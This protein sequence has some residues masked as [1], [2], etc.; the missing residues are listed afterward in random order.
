LTARALPL[1]LLVMILATAPSTAQQLTPA[2]SVDTA[3]GYRASLRLDGLFADKELQQVLE[4]GLPMRVR[5]RIE[6]WRDRM[7]DA[8]KG[9]EIW[10]ALLTYNPL[11]KTY[12]LRT[13]GSP[14]IDHHLSSFQNARGALEARRTFSL[15]PSEP[16]RY[17]FTANIEIETLSLSDLEELERWL[18]GELRPAVSG[19]RSV[20]SAIGEGA[21]RMLVR[22]LSLPTRTLDLKTPRFRVTSSR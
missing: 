12:R 17:Y 3:G 8:S 13:H 22:I 19:D 7:I 10:N 1:F 14:S 4:S 21:K 15:R 6:L 11:E 20:P 5:I 16:G 2:L 18:Q 9:S